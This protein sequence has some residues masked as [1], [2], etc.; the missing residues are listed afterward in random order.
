M[1]KIIVIC[2]EA[3]SFN[4]D[5]AESGENETAFELIRFRAPRSF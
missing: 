1:K 3:P 2:L 5:I 4:R